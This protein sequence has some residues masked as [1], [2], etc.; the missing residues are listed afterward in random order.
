MIAMGDKQNN[1]TNSGSESESSSSSSSDGDAEDAQE[2]K[3]QERVTLLNR[4]LEQYPNAYDLYTEL[5]ASL[6]QLGDL[7]QLTA[8]RERMNAV[9]PLSPALWLDW[10]KDARSIACTPDDK[11]QVECLFKRAID[12]YEDVD[13]WLEY[14]HFAIGNYEPGSSESAA[15]AYE[16]F[17][18]A[19][20]HQGLNVA[21]GIVLWE[22]YREFQFL[23]LAQLP[24]DETQKIDEH[25]RKIDKLFRRQLSVPLM[26]MQSTLAEYEDFLKGVGSSLYPS[27]NSNSPIPADCM[28]DY[29]KALAQLESLLEY[30]EKIENLSD[31]D[32]LTGSVTVWETYLDWADEN[33]RSKTTTDGSGTKRRQAKA[34]NSTIATVQ[35]L[36]PNQICCLFERAVTAHCLS[37]TIWLRFINYLED[38]LGVDKL[39][40]LRTFARAVRNCPW[41]VALWVRYAIATEVAVTEQ[42]LDGGTNGLDATQH[43]DVEYRAFTKVETVFE[44]AL[45]SGLQ[46]HS[47]LLQL[48]IAYCDY[49]LRRLLRAQKNSPEWEIQLSNL[50]NTFDRASSE[51]IQQFEIKSDPEASLPRYR[52]LIEAKFVGDVGAAR[53]VWSLLMQ[54]PGRGSQSK[55]W[56]AY[57]E[58][59]RD[60]GDVKHFLK[61]C[62]MAL[63]SINEP[64]D[65][66]YSSILRLSA[67]IGLPSEQYYELES[68]IRS[69]QRQLEQRRRA[70]SDLA[71]PANS[72]TQTEGKPTQ[73][74]AP[75]TDGVKSK[76]RQKPPAA[77]LP[78]KKRGLAPSSDS[79]PAK[80]TR[81][82]SSKPFQTATATVS[83]TS[84][85]TDATPPVHGERVP[86]DPARENRTVFVSNLD[87]SIDESQLRARFEPCGVLTSVRLVRDY[88]GRSKGFAYVEFD[89]EKAVPVALALDRQ[90]VFGTESRATTDDVQGPDAEQAPL[91][92]RPM[93]V[94][95]CDP[96]RAKTDGAFRYQAGRAEPQKLFVRN[97][98]KHVTK[99]ALQTLFGQHGT[100]VDVRLA[101]YR[102]GTPK[103]HAYVE[104]ATANEASRALIATDGL[105]VGSKEIAVAISNPPVR[106]Q[107]QSKSGSATLSDMT[108]T[109]SGT[110]DSMGQPHFAVPIAP[111]SKPRTHART[112]LS[113][114]PRA[115]H[116]TS[117]ASA[118]ASVNE[119]PVS[120]PT[121]GKNNEDFRKLFLS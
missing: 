39:R 85:A 52:A 28:E 47:D 43:S 110:T 64:T 103:G 84:T 29:K 58:F 102:N 63:N 60:W 99:D 104:F 59:E 105:L 24:K 10:I 1:D 70:T 115:I 7:D 51:L 91:F 5:I 15:V 80:K 38:V 49:R 88:A 62:R 46:N 4:Q 73:A 74:P 67:E 12:D 78:G 116:R 71:E 119:N 3:L 20:S 54:S 17:E 16:I 109:H 75:T 106:N 31:Q 18:S 53:S 61:I 55:F 82:E 68:R 93:F 81:T 107:S 56:L 77:E 8:A 30:E 86:H 121:G 87:F 118:E 57:L 90:P 11:R 72:Q 92:F 34:S 36:S 27:E 44:T 25:L 113:F 41:S 9:Y 96:T 14:C 114:L 83:T 94:S 101:T 98:D 108:S 26:N 19:L 40:L 22:V 2:T 37:P 100:V 23:I 42:L 6:K 65:T 76:N 45:L 112:Q 120:E 13:I 33:A 111:A 66:V 69:R 21:S 79:V 35:P 97:L 32:D 117:N 50:R 48:W 95:R 89:D